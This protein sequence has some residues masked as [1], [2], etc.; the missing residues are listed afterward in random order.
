M[1]TTAKIWI[2]TLL[3]SVLIQKS[4]A[5]LQEAWLGLWKGKLEIFD[6]RSVKQTITIQMELEINRIDSTKWQWKMVYGEGEKK[7]VRDYELILKNAE[8]GHYI[9]DEKNTISMDMQLH[10]RHFTSFFSVDSAL[11][12]ITYTLKDDKTLVFEV[13]SASEK[14]KYTTGKGDKEIPFVVSYPCKGYQKA[15]L[16]KTHKVV[17]P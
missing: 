14:E 5:Q 9:I 16:H 17:K 4:H 7:D 2:L 11:L 10:Y 8:K 15:V 6:T 1:K 12:C 13:I 3:L